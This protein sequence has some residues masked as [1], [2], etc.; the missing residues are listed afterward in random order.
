MKFHCSYHLGDQLFTLFFL[1]N[2]AKY[3]PYINFEFYVPPQYLA[4][5]GNF[6]APLP[7]IALTSEPGGADAWI[8]Q[9]RCYW[10]MRVEEKFVDFLIE[11]HSYLAR[12]FG[13]PDW[14]MKDRREMLLPMSNSPKPHKLSG[15]YFDVLFVN[16]QALS[17]QCPNWNQDRLNELAL[18]LSSAGLNVITTHPTGYD[19][20]ATTSLGLSLAQVGELA[21]RCIMVAGV[22][23]APFLA[24]FNVKAFP[25]VQYWIN[26]SIDRVNFDN[27]RVVRALSIQGLEE[28]IRKR[29]L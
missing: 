26:Y 24:T 23:N 25:K 4:E 12:K 1:N 9:D 19:I 21:S 20:P 16:S 22:A 2:A 5:V 10:T 15:H 29:M 3:W 13:L 18:R 8:G 7:N 11:F 14:P 27:D 6:V 17:N 28:E